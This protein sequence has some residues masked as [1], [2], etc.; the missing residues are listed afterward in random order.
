MSVSGYESMTNI[1]QLKTIAVAKLTL[2]YVMTLLG[3]YATHNNI[4][5][6][7]DSHVILVL[8]SL[9]VDQNMVNLKE[10]IEIYL[11]DVDA[12]DE[13]NIFLERLRARNFVMSC[14]NAH[15]AGENPVDSLMDDV[16]DD[17]G[18]IMSDIERKEEPDVNHCHC[19]LVCQNVITVMEM[20]NQQYQHLCNYHRD[21]KLVQLVN[22]HR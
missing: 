1:D 20:S 18:H 12:H 13:N 7:D 5:V 19:S 6:V 9:L 10:A 21:Q 3:I 17:G 15:S 22:S 11:S 14:I 2:E 8:K 4:S 16:I